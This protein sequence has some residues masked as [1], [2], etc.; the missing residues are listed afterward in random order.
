MSDTQ[1]ELHLDIDF[2]SKSAQ[3][4]HKISTDSYKRHGST[5]TRMKF[6]VVKNLRCL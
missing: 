1:S 2:L 4:M 5:K 6:L 3:K